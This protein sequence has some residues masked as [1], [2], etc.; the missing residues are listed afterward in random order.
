MTGFWATVWLFTKYA[1]L[2]GGCFMLT[3]ALIVIFHPIHINLLGRLSLK[4][5]RGAVTLSYLFNILKIRF[6]AS[7]H[8]QDI[9]LHIFGFKRLLQR[10]TRERKKVAVTVSESQTSESV[11]KQETTEKVEETSFAE[12]KS[13]KEEL[14]KEESVTTTTQAAEN[15]SSDTVEQEKSDSESSETKEVVEDKTESVPEETSSENAK[16]ETSSEALTETDPSQK[17][18]EIVEEKTPEKPVQKKK[19]SDFHAMLRKFKK[20]ANRRYKELQGKLRLVKQKWNSL[21]PVVKRFWQRGKKGFSFYGARLM[22]R[23]SLDEHYL[24]GMMY[25]YVA[26]MIGFAQRYGLAFEP[27]AAFPDKPDYTV[28]SKVT[29]NIDIKPWRLMWAVVCLLFEKNLYKE[30]IWLYKRKKKK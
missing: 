9:W 13:E 23:Y 29:W 16:E 24:T 11:E 12:E 26:P 4:G 10:E 22:V 19:D 20:D 28:Y 7:R 8:T 14:E 17:T 5:Q 2:F 6:V 1:A 30:I 27:V 18:E 21:F 3:V 25:G 15:N